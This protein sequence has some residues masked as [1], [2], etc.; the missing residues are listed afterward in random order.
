M[1]EKWWD[2]SDD[3]LDDLFREASDKAD[4]PFDSSA[5]D[6]LRQKIDFKP[7][8][9]PLQ[10]FKKGWLAL[11]GLLLLLGVALLYIFSGENDGLP[12]KNRPNTVF[13]NKS[14]STNHIPSDSI[15]NNQSNFSQK[16]KLDKL[17]NL[18]KSNR[19]VVIIDENESKVNSTS[20][21]N[22][23][24]SKIIKDKSLIPLENS[25][26]Q[27]WN[28]KLIKNGYS[29]NK[30]S[31]VKDLSNSISEDNSLDI[32]KIKANNEETKAIISESE[33]NQMSVN[34][35]NNNN[36]EENSFIVS[37]ASKQNRKTSKLKKISYNDGQVNNSS[38][39]SETNTSIST[40]I[41]ISE[42]K[43]SQ[44]E[45]IA[46]MNFHQIDFLSNKPI[47][48]LETNI[49]SE[50]LTYV[51]APPIVLKQPKFSRF[52]IRLA[53]A[54]EISSIE[55]METSAVVGGLFGLLLEYRLTKK[56][57]LQTGIN[58]SKKTYT[59]DFEYY[60]AWMDVTGTKPVN[61][62][63]ICNVVDIPINLRLNAFQ[64]KYNTF[65]VS[66]GVSSYLM[67]D[68]VYT[69]NYA[70]GPPK[71]RD[72]TGSSSSFYWSTL[73]LSV[74]V[75]R[76][77]NKHFTLQVEPFLKTPLMGVGRGLVN[78]YSSGLLFSTKYEF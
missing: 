54:P 66:G 6:K 3:E 50:P 20:S 64:M 8:P 9:P 14:P 18:P 38:L 34:E 73:N 46:E 62:D 35:S 7:T 40:P 68:E 37:N 53:I 43:P 13:E 1:S 71:I 58:Y 47:K 11:T 39:Y 23:T 69:Y 70:W 45:T 72:W 5:L 44:E 59:G 28:K 61:I 27:K 36:S 42:N 78:L 21:K 2:M 32:S 4:I 55:K 52:G 56:L 26:N 17:E 22:T 24:E 31:F 12:L 10:G 25:S 15:E 75:E 57:T 77:M 19:T 41:T 63:G 30:K 65:F 48:S 16:E 67:S 60:R 74:G 76:K 29:L 49:T 33:K 51:D